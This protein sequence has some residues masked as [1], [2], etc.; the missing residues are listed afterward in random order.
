MEAL[1]KRESLPRRGRDQKLKNKCLVVLI[2]FFAFSQLFPQSEDLLKI[3]ASISPG[4]LIRGQ[5]GKVI[6][7]FTLEEG[8]T[9]NPLPS[10]T[11]EISPS[12][13]LVFPKNFF[14][15]SDLEI[16]ILEEGGKEYLDLSKQIE[17]PF[18]VSSEAQRGTHNLE[19]KIKYFAVSRSEN[20]CL[21]TKS[22]FSASF[23]VRV[24]LEH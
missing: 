7:D 2:V 16:E 14:A 21:K 1:K 9:V 23:Y 6:L 19:G 22:D 17:I 3:K 10:F 11:I 5:D 20:W 4:R 8:L 18:K 13:V 15:A 12:D 24:T